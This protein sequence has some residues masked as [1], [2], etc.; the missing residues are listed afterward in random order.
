VPSF[1][2]RRPDFRIQIAVAVF[3]GFPA[4]TLCNLP[5]N[6]SFTW[7]A[8]MHLMCVSFRFVSVNL[9]ISGRFLPLIVLEVWLVIGTYKVGRSFAG[10]FRIS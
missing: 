10:A 8:M 3:Y 7:I 1:P 4:G 5:H 2:P 9:L 6:S